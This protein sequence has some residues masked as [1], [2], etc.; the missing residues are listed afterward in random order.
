MLSY[1]GYINKELKVG[2]KALPNLSVQLIP[3]KNEL[4]Q[5][6]VVGYGT[7]KKSDVTG[8]ITSISEQSIKDVPASNLA[9]ALQ[10]QGAG[11]DIQRSGANSKPGATPNILIRGLRSLGA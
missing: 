7:R 2:N 6:I 11:I 5:I 8:A 10:G 9:S 4:D 1:V 3:N